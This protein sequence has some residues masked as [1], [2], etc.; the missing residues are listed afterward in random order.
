MRSKF[1]QNKYYA[2]SENF[3]DL[4][5]SKMPSK[6]NR[7]FGCIRSAE[8]KSQEILFELDKMISEQKNKSKC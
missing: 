7:A 2:Q 8:I 6:C 1:L 5:D 4:K 3:S